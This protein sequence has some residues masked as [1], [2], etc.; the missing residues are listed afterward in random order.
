LRALVRAA[1]RELSWGL[2]LV[3][4]ELVRWRRRATAIPNGE[5]RAD[6]LNA[7]D[8]KR[9][10]TD[11]A[12]VFATLLRR[13]DRDV[14]L[15]LAL[16][17]AL[18]DYLDSSVER[19]P[20]AANGRELHL[21]LVD[22]L[23][24]SAP[25]SDYYRH[26]PWGDDGGYLVGMVE[27]CRA[28]CCRLP[29]YDEVQAAVV[30]EARRA[31]VQALNHLPERQARDA[32]LLEWA[33]ADAAPDEGATWFEVTAAASAS[34]VILPLLALAADPRLTAREV[35]AARDGYRPWVTVVTTML[36]NYADQAEDVLNG[37]HNYFTHYSSSAAG[38]ERLCGGMRRS[39][40]NLA[41]LPYGERHIVV[42][43][44]MVAMYLSKTGDGT[45][46]AREE[47]CRLAR[48]G[49]PLVRFL[50]PVLRVWRLVYGVAAR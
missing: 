47:R 19:H 15:L 34:L 24:P 28:R 26:H 8:D 37:N 30:A 40:R 27:W 29:S 48:A 44:A 25:L 5:L 41:A 16:Y 7:L 23:E 21:A 11:G 35:K 36:D 9:T 13:R 38:V 18:W 39:F 6:A 20:T 3:G 1:C 12:A 32:A 42:V 46:A 50:V 43:A 31:E 14:L 2:P 22:A 45:A 17:Q 49:G 4:R 33:R 10:N